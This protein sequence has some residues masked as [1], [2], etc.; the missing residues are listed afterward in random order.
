MTIGVIGRKAGMTRIFT[1]EGA[2]IPVTVIE[3]EPNRVVQMRTLEIDGY[4]AVQVTIG[5]PK[6]SHVSKPLA[7]HFAKAGIEAGRRCVEFRLDEGEGEDLAVG[8]EIDIS[9]FQPGQKVDVQGRTKGRGFSGVIRRYHFSAQR[10]THGDR[11]SV[12]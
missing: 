12:V 1:P 11:K 4:R 6:A 7:G 10:A 5:H 2:S 8:G 9:V 3:V